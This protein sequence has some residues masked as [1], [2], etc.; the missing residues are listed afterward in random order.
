MNL[1]EKSWNELFLISTVEQFLPMAPDSTALVL[2]RLLI[3]QQ[4]RFWDDARG[5][6]HTSCIIQQIKGDLSHIRQLIC[7]FREMK[8]NAAEIAFLKSIILFR[9]ETH[10]LK[11][12]TNNNMYSFVK[13]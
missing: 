3:S 5:T 8:V 13:H 4:H 10:G 11:V 12:I 6:S 7:W 9:P 1:L 2:S